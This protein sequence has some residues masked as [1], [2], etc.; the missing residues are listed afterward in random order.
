[1]RQTLG[2]LAVLALF[3]C[4][5]SS[6]TVQDAPS[7][8]AVSSAQPASGDGD[9]V[10]LEDS[11]QA[12]DI[13][14][15]ALATRDVP[16]KRRLAR[17]LA[18]IA[19]DRSA[20]IL[21]G[22]L[23]LDDTETLAYVSYGLGFNCAS[24]EEKH[25][26]ALAARYASLPPAP[27][28]AVNGGFDVRATFL[29]ALAHCG[30]E[31][32]EST[33]R[34]ALSGPDDADRTRA[35]FALGDMAARRRTLSSDSVS[36][37]LAAA[38]GDQA[39]PAVI[40]AFY[41]LSRLKADAEL[42][43]LDAA[44]R[45]LERPSPERVFVIRALAKGGPEA[46]PELLRV[47]KNTQFRPEERAEAARA[48]GLMG[49]I[50]QTTLAEAI[51][52][53]M[54]AKDPF[55]VS[56]LGGPLYGVLSNLLDGAKDDPPK[57][58]SAALFS[59]A[60]FRAPG[61]PSG[62]L[63]RRIGAL[64]C[65]AAAALAKGSIDAEVL[66]QCDTKG[67]TAWESARLNAL[68][69]KPLLRE[70][71][72]AWLEL[73]KSPNVRVREEALQAFEQHG[74]LSEAGRDAL[75]VALQ[76]RQAGLTAIAA[77]VIF[78]RPERAFSV[79][80]RER[81]AALDPHAPPPAPFESPDK[82]I[83]PR[84][85]TALTE[86]LSFAWPEDAVET[87]TLLLDAASAVHLKGAALFAKKSCVDANV[88]VRKRAQAALRLLGEE[89]SCTS[90][91]GAARGPLP[92]LLSKDVRVVFRTDAGEL[93]LTLEPA[94]APLATT[95]LLALVQQGFYKNIV[96]HRVVPGFVV[97][98]GDPGADGYGG[99]GKLLRCET[100][101]V[102]FE[103]LSVGIALA[104][105]DTGSSQLFVTLSR[106]PHLDG[107]YSLVGHADGDWASVAEGDVIQD[108]RAQE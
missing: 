72:A 59:V 6:G 3:A 19:D 44:Q 34:A 85:A 26:R 79:S 62:S 16:K 107:E 90:P 2:R 42:P 97:Q 93:G 92:P 50:G 17:A 33:L 98:F 69:K 86:A 56:T 71:R 88:T 82:E 38:A 70:R 18:R 58:L 108:A 87:R 67:S 10:A 106:T 22:A 29:R 100:S 8:S 20:E 55:A 25:V 36:A 94:L 54:P 101:P 23:P 37:L 49:A 40:S 83:D 76:S 39:H 5:K 80:S 24:R 12:L 14:K 7:A 96:V 27:L 48:I 46:L 95:R 66:L 53:L 51:V 60:S 61:D 102:P 89:A 4:S 74:E 75:I 77:E 11:R 103:P 28:P 43:L 64:R 9:M 35:A 91:T 68:L 65:K 78:K 41:P 30:G 47:V 63:G 73:V 99:S 84:I 31:L 15:D 105:R 57:A 52:A 32:A 13:A 21:L 1:M 104:G 81:K 45:A